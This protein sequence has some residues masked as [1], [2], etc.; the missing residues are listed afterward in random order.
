MLPFHVILYLYTYDYSKQRG[1]SVLWSLAVTLGWGQDWVLT[2]C[3][4]AAGRS[5]KCILQTACINQIASG[6]TV[7]L[8]PELVFPFLFSEWCEWMCKPAKMIKSLPHS[9]RLFFICWE[10][11]RHFQL[12]QRRYITEAAHFL[13]S[14][15][16]FPVPKNEKWNIT[17]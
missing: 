6:L 1:I 17:Y 14:F 12:C 13:P 7:Q 16:S 8:G 2:P 9:F 4:G 11:A 5:L 10:I 15:F 3:R